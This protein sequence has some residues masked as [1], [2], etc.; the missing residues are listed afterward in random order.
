MRQTDMPADESYVLIQTA[1]DHPIAIALAESLLQEAGIP[2]FVPDQE[3]TAREDN[4]L[5]WWDVRIPRD[6]EFEAREIVRSVETLK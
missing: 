1:L 3:V 6:R 5:G 4:A 2:Y